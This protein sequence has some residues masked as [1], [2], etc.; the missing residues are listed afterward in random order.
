VGVKVGVAYTRSERA[1]YKGTESKSAC[2]IL[3]DESNIS[4]FTLRVT[5]IITDVCRTSALTITRKSG[6]GKPFWVNR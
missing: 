4:P 6:R 2:Y 3:S 5:G 1:A